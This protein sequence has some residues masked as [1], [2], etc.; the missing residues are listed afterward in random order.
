M[1][2]PLL[3]PSTT[4][5][6]GLSIV[7]SLKTFDIVQADDPGRSG[8]RVGDARRDD[9]PRHLRQQRVRD[10][11]SAVAI[12]LTVITV[13]ASMIYL[14]RQLAMGEP[15]RRGAPRSGAPAHVPRIASAMSS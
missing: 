14:R 9:V 13:G 11:A 15:P 10:S 5:V 4:I 12:F 3:R 2:W 1:V 6:V 8:P 7:N